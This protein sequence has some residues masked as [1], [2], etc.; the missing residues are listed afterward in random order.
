M[1]RKTNNE[2]QNDTARQDNTRVVIQNQMATQLTP[3][4]KQ[5]LE[6]RKLQEITER[7]KS[8]IYDADRA[9]YY[10]NMQNFYNNNF[11]GYGM[12]GHQTNLDPTNPEGQQAI[13]SNFDYAKSNVQNLAE[14]VAFTGLAS[15]ASNTI[16][17]G[18]KLYSKIFKGP[19]RTP[20]KR[21]SLGTMS[22]YTKNGTLGSGAE[23]VVINNTPL[24]VGKMTTIPQS[25]MV[26]RNAIPNTVQSKYIGFVK[27]KGVKLP[28]YIQNKVRTLTEDTFPRYINKL[29]NAMSK[30]GFRRVTDPNVQYRAYTNGQVVVDDVA[31]GNVGL[32]WLGRPKMIDFNL[33]SV[34][35]WVSQG[36]TLKDGGKLISKH[37]KGTKVTPAYRGS[38]Q[39]FPNMLENQSN[40]LGYYDSSNNFIPGVTGYYNNKG[41]MILPLQRVNGETNISLPNVEITPK[42][43]NLEAVVDKGKR[44]AAPYIGAI[45]GGAAMG[46][47]GG[48]GLLKP[49]INPIDV[50]LVANDPSD[51]SNWIPFGMYSA[52]KILNKGKNITSVYY[53]NKPIGQYLRFVGGK[54]KYGFDAKLPDLIRRTYNPMSNESNSLIGKRIVV[55]PI[56][57]RFVWESSKQPSPIITNFTTDLPVI[58][59][60]IGDWFGSDINIIKGNYLLGKNVIS[61]RPM[62]TFIY[63]NRMVVPK[64]AIKTISSKQGT[65]PEQVLKEE[66]LKVYRRPTLKDY[67]FM[68]YVFQP[69]Y[70]SNVI[71]NTPLTFENIDTHP[72]KK[73]FFDGDMRDRID[74]PWKHVMYE[75]NP[76]IERD[77]REDLGIILKPESKN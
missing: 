69:K 11:F 55:S 20:S 5:A 65:V 62:D 47:M 25:E 41:S 70:T 12:F 50:G 39:E 3:E 57:N 9:K 77:F 24:T 71:P 52:P 72:F 67:Q 30:S 60:S 59:H 38:E 17:K 8:F 63:G 46:A 76:P 21:G 53:S 75:L 34:S 66:F 15:A 64:R 28:T 48:A 36:F 1:E 35:D 68:D 74:Q 14:N 18:S 23:A 33:Q 54:F 61:T 19:F 73:Y 10:Q 22:Q 43:I 40:K 56:E 49:L 31:P 37:Q 7:N 29:D 42:N 44:E 13:Q 58:P 16:T 45:V 32:D 4:Q 6:Q 26:A 51:A 2:Y 27:D